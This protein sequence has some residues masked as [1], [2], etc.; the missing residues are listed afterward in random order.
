MLNITSE[1][2]E[3]EVISSP[4]PV[5]VDFFATWCGPCKMLSPIV[6]ELADEY[7]EKLRF[8]KVNVD[9]ERELALKFGITSIPTLLFFKSGKLVN[10]VVGYRDKNQLKEITDAL[11]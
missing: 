11:V 9:D 1:N 5:V 7:G 3:K 4:V 6:E 10:N 8:C 2:F